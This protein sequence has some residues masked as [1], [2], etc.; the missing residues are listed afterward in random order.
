[1]KRI[2]AL[3]IV[4]AVLTSVFAAVSTNVDTPSSATLN[5]ALEQKYEFAF[6]KDKDDLTKAMD[7]FSLNT[8]GEALEKSLELDETRNIFYFYYKVYT[9]ETNLYIK[10]DASNPLTNTEGDSINYSVKLETLSGWDAAGFST[11][12]FESGSTSEAIIRSASVN[13]AKFNLYGICKVTID[14]ASGVKLWEKKP[15]SYSAPIYLKLT[16]TI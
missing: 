10:F 2:L 11:T 7:S 13:S 1:M 15:G 9:G 8:K 4:L 14:D 5:L 12:G 3:L 6:V 16:T